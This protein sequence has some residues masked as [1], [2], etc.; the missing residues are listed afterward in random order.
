VDFL[1]ELRQAG[2]VNTGRVMPADWIAYMGIGGDES[3]SAHAALA[4]IT[5]S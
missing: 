5:H 4:G 1:A 3:I 2:H